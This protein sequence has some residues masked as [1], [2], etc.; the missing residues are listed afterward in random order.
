MTE[1]YELFAH[2]FSIPLGNGRVGLRLCSRIEMSADE[3]EDSAWVHLAPYGTWRGHEEGPFTLDKSTFKNII[4]EFEKIEND[5]QIDYHHDSIKEDVTGPRPAS[6]WIKAMEIRGTGKQKGDGLWAFV[7]WTKRAATFIRNKEFKYLS[8]V[9]DFLSKDRKSGK[10]NSPELFN[11]AL[12]NDP[13]L[14]GQMPLALER[15][16]LQMEIKI[17]DKQEGQAVAADQT[18]PD[19]AT[20]QDEGAAGGSIIDKIA[21]AVGLEP[22]AVEALMLEKMDDIVAI[23]AGAQNTDGT[24]AD[25]AQAADIPS[26]TV[27][28]DKWEQAKRDQSQLTLDRLSKRVVDL[29]KKDRKAQEEKVDA[30]IAEKIE[31]GEILIGS[32]AL[33][34]ELYLEDYDR[35]ERIYCSKVV[36]IGVSQS[37]KSA[38]SGTK[39]NLTEDEKTAISSLVSFGYSKDNAT[40]RIVAQ[41]KVN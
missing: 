19:A 2:P 1:K 14:D 9:I 39:D 8:P 28:A 27:A 7:A 33:A 22:S 29:E 36:P 34:R 4:S 20:M 6:G 26:Q 16:P 37:T 21:E 11:A 35:A 15:L 3:T 31:N 38:K 17:K 40:Q 25:E 24:P 12:T 5:I 32:K 13:F 10:K 18:Q 23:V 30:R 41:R